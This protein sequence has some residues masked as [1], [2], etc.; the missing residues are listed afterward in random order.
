V[1]V[2]LD[3]CA[4]IWF[5][6][7]ERM[8]PAGLSGIRAAESRGELVVPAVALW[9]V[10][11]LARRGRL[12]LE[13]PVERWLDRVERL[14]GYRVEPLTGAM[15]RDAANLE[16]P[17]SND[18]ADRFIVATARALG[19]PVAT[20]DGQIIALAGAGEVRILEV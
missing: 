15:A 7:G 6:T 8:R 11:R 1:T 3:T 4:L 18:P 20:R 14:P 9:E 16:P 2:V 19:A 10:A 12:R 17:L 13:E 5:V